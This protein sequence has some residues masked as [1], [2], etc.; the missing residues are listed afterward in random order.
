MSGRLPVLV[1]GHGLLVFLATLSGLCGIA[2]EVLLGRVLHNVLG[3]HFTV[4]SAVLLAFMAGLGVG[5][6]VARRWWRHLWLIEL[7]IGGY[8]LLFPGISSLVGGL[9]R[10]GGEGALWPL[11]LGAMVVFPPAFLIGCG[12]PLFAGYLARLSPRWAFQRVYGFYNLGAAV[13]VLVVEFWLIRRLGLTASLWAMASVNF[14]TAWILRRRFAE[15]AALPLPA[16]AATGGWRLEERVSLIVAS[17]ASAIFQS[18]ALK[19]SDFLLGPFREGFALVLA[20]VLGGLGAGSFLAARYRLAFGHF[21]LLAVVGLLWLFAAYQPVVQLHAA[22]Y[23]LAEAYPPLGH[24]A[25]KLATLVALTGVPAVAFGGLV[26]AL[27]SSREEVVGESGELLFLSSLANAVGFLAMVGYLHLHFDYGAILLGVGQLV[28]LAWLLAL[29]LTVGRVLLAGALGGLLWFHLGHDWQEKRLY[30]GHTVHRSLETLDQ[31]TKRFVRYLPFKGRRDVVAITTSEGRGSRFFFNGYESIPLSDTTEVMVGVLS[32]MLTP[33]GE[34][35]ALVLGLGT[36]KTASGVNLLLGET[37]VVEINPVIIGMQPYLAGY[38]LDLLGQK[39]VRLHDADATVFVRQCRRPYP[40]IVNTVTTPLYFSAAKLYTRD[41]LEDVRSCLTRDGVYMTWMDY[42]VGEVGA[43]IM[44]KTLGEV[45][46]HA[47]L[48]A[49]NG[50]YFL[51]F[52]S[53]TPLALHRPGLVAASP[54][55]MD[56]FMR[57]DGVLPEWIPYALIHPDPVG[58]VRD[59]EVVVNTLDR[60]VLEFALAEGEG[61][62]GFLR[63]VRWLATTGA[64]GEMARILGSATAWDPGVRHHFLEGQLGD[65]ADL[66]VADRA[67]LEKEGVD[68]RRVKGEIALA[69]EREMAER[70]R[71]AFGWR[72]WGKRM[73][74]MNQCGEALPELERVL[75]AHPGD[76]ALLHQAGI[77]RARLGDLDGGVG[78][79]R[80]ALLKSP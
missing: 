21:L 40:L 4:S 15:V 35:R 33:P 16:P 69:A 32:A 17:F 37:D 76:K 65:D 58:Y 27:I 12:I 20:V 41:F 72:R 80:R 10:S 19:L 3:D 66:V 36:G 30:F 54:P 68:W 26:P 73:V 50:E 34:D 14:V 44:L 52:A 6:L 56:Y 1:P 42:R 39:G 7:A 77:C 23:P 67:A 78:Y 51:L 49:M 59:R 74:A 60:P 53:A 24:V 38:N 75:A 25:L 11:L 63:F 5:A 71:D 29:G 70:L 8:A 22:L 28:L 62:K 45:F 31:A 2:Y 64:R 46:P 18:L 43:A 61:G 79:L 9:L 55:L 48:A 13:T 47:W 57:R